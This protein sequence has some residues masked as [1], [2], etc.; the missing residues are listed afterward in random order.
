M[1]AYEGYETYSGWCSY[2]I[3]FETT[4]LVPYV[5]K[6]VNADFALYKP[7]SRKKII[8]VYEVINKNK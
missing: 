2:L 4:G 1:K 6:I 8:R 3:T 5:T 7:A